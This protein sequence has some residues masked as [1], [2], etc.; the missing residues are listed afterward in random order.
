MAVDFDKIILTFDHPR[1]TRDAQLAGGRLHFR[2]FEPR[3]FH[4]GMLPRLA[5]DVAN[6]AQKGDEYWGYALPM[7]VT[8]QKKA[9]SGM[10]AQLSAFWATLERNG[11]VFIEGCTGRSTANKKQADAMFDEAHKIITRGGKRLPRMD[12]AA[13]RKRKTFP[14]QEVELLAGIV[15]RSPNVSSDL[16]AIR[17]CKEL[18][19]NQ[20]SDRLIR[21]LGP[22]GRAKR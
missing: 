17:L 21:S 7:I 18:W 20:I 12:I 1:M 16:A 15:W 2:G 5:I 3:V 8:S 9:G 6:A 10:P 4:V 14:A 19:P 11:G 22:S 13:G